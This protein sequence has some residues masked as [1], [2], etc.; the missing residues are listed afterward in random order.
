MVGAP[1]TQRTIPP[2]HVPLGNG[3][4][5]GIDANGTGNQICRIL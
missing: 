1:H 2:D 3:V 4:D 5:D